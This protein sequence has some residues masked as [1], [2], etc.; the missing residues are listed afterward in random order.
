M[1]SI[2][3]S[4]QKLTKHIYVNNILFART[5]FDILS[6]FSDNKTEKKR[7]GLCNCIEQNLSI[8]C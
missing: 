4:K 6:L 7:H 3:K 5:I 8:T 1:L 2:S